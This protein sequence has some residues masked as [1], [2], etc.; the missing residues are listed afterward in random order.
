MGQVPTAEGAS[1]KQVG[2]GDSQS[3]STQSSNVSGSPSKVK[4]VPYLNPDPYCQFIGPKNLGEALI[5]EELMTC[6]LDNGSQLNFI[7]LAYACK[8]GV[9]IM[10]LDSERS[11]NL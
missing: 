10:S 7:T 4:G 8:R 9:D 1:P 2:S 5:D 6:L 3:L 11:R